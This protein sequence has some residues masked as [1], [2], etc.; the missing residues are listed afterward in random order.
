MSSGLS[1]S[2]LDTESMSNTAAKP[3]WPFLGSCKALTYVSC[4]RKL[5]ASLCKASPSKQSLNW[6]VPVDFPPQSKLITRS[7]NYYM[8]MRGGNNLAAPPRFDYW[9]H[10][11]SDPAW[12]SAA[13]A[14]RS[15]SFC[16]WEGK[17][18][19]PSGW[20]MSVLIL[21]AS[22]LGFFPCKSRKR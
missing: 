9:A 14:T 15:H 8:H 22:L 17:S 1:P 6:Q 7:F 3:H 18:L 16:W 21:S 4:K 5:A 13:G 19:Q 2:G 11:N 12:P 20:A 10:T